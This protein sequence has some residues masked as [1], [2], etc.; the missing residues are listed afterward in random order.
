MIDTLV[1]RSGDAVGGSGFALLSGAELGLAVI[2]AV[3][4]PVT[5][6]WLALCGGLGRRHNEALGR[7]RGRTDAGATGG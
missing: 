6:F 2:S 3:A 4:I 1:Q 7:L 5:A